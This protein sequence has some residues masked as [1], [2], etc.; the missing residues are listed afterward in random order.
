[1][2]KSCCKVSQKDNDVTEFAC[3]P[4]IKGSVRTQ[5][6]PVVFCGKWEVLQYLR[7]FS[8]YFWPIDLNLYKFQISGWWN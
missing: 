3:I 6:Q 8:R 2:Q 1:M 4:F 7:H 5:P